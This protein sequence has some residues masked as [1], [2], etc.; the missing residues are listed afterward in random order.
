MQLAEVF[1][2]SSGTLTGLLAGLLLGFSISVIPG[3][4]LM[5][6]QQHIKAMQYINVKIKNPIFLITLMG[7]A[8]LL[9]IVAV[10]QQSDDSFAYLATS[11]A[12]YIVGVI[13]VTMFGNV[14]LNDQLDAVDADQLSTSEAEHVR[15]EYHGIGARWMLLHHIRTVAAIAATAQV[16]IAALSN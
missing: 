14:P 6:A 3:L 2:V 12:L 8:V 7:P 15:T 11:A 5:T 10:Q 1:L 9:P 4:R 13:A 16:F